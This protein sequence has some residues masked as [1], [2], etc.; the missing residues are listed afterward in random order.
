MI[1]RGTIALK[2]G[3]VKTVIVT[4]TGRCGTTAVC[5]VCGSLGFL[6]PE[7]KD[8]RIQ[9]CRILA[10]AIACNNVGVI[11]AMVKKYSGQMW[12]WKR[13]GFI[14]AIIPQLSLFELPGL[15]VVMRDTVA[16][17]T[18]H[19]SK[20]ADEAVNVGIEMARQNYELMVMSHS[21]AH[22][23]PVLLV[24]Y[25]Q[26]LANTEEAINGLAGFLGVPPSMDAVAQVIPKDVRYYG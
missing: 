5:R 9:E 8:E 22:A 21:A 3:L 26:L 15:I 2:N 4:G 14:R 25:E 16:T 12:G 18:S 24:S 19:L 10:D 6:W 13:P 23:V 17:T 11:K 1:N 7:V 20:S